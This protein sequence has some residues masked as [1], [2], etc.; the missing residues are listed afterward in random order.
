[1]RTRPS[2]LKEW[3]FQ[4]T[5]P[6]EGGGG[7]ILMEPQVPLSKVPDQLRANHPYRLLLLVHGLNGTRQRS[8][9]KRPK[10]SPQK[11]AYIRAPDVANGS[12]TVRHGLRLRPRHQQRLVRLLV[13]VRTPRGGK[14]T[15]SSRQSPLVR[16]DHGPS[17]CD[18]QRRKC[19]LRR[20]RMGG[21][22]VVRPSP[23]RYRT[24]LR[25]FGGA[26]VFW[27]DP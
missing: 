22:H 14:G 10:A 23:E 17:L 16:Q 13:E 18:R 5:H 8:S 3:V 25:R 1:V 21:D 9:R 15:S 2:P 19:R 27:G 11:K 12:R 6:I 24:F 7:G 20:G 4:A 26:I